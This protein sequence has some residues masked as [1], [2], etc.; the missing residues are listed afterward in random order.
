MAG[1]ATAGSGRAFRLD[2][3]TLPVRSF[4]EAGA[5]TAAAFVIEHTH[6]VVRRAAGDTVTVPVA[7]Y[8]GVAVRM[9]STGDNGEVRAYVELLHADASLTLPLAVTDDP[10]D[11]YADWQAWAKALDLPL[12]VVG[13]DGSVGGPLAGM[14]GIIAAR[15]QPRRRHSFFAQRRPRFLARRKAGRPGAAPRVEGREIIARD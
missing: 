2:P 15:P 13:Q 4:A 1:G 8:R 11:I 6:A 14:G 3:H 9:E 7:E 12:L 5:A 10:Y